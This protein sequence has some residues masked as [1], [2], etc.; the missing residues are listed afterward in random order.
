MRSDTHQRANQIDRIGASAKIPCPL[1]SGVGTI[2]RNTPH[3]R[4]QKSSCVTVDWRSGQPAR[5]P[6]S[7]CNFFFLE[8]K[9][10]T[11]SPWQRDLALLRR[12]KIASFLSF[13]RVF[14][15]F[16]RKAKLD[17]QEFIVVRRICRQTKRHVA[18]FDAKTA[19]L[20]R[21]RRYS[22][23]QVIYSIRPQARAFLRRQEGSP[24]RRRALFCRLRADI[25]RVPCPQEERCR[26]PR[27][28]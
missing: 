17:K 8:K 19:D 5:L 24:F 22:V 16:C 28:A 27:R 1:L 21:G 11:V 26:P 4:E 20:Q 7:F 14:E 10:L 9:K 25:F 23:C 18:L 2:S 15:P 6:T 3:L 13:Q 12:R